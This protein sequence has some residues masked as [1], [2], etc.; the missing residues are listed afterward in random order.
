MGTG[1]MTS[2]W[3]ADAAD[4]R[5]T[6][7]QLNRI[8][9]IRRMIDSAEF[10]AKELSCSNTRKPAVYLSIWPNRPRSLSNRPRD[11]RERISTTKAELKNHDR[12]ALRQVPRQEA[13]EDSNDGFDR[14]SH[15][16]VQISSK[17]EHDV[18]LDYDSDS[19]SRA[20][21]EKTNYSESESPETQT[22]PSTTVG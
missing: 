4:A 11:A 9:F 19:C 2:K 5:S 3:K 16:N 7:T 17:Q 15:G 12:T 18:C 8:A 21:T 1:K 20:S 14:L 13:H 10:S 6:N 22:I